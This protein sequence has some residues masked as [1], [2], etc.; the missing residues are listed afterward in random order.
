M[1]FFLVRLFSLLALVVA[2]LL[3]P[4]VS[5]F[6]EPQQCYATLDFSEDVGVSRCNG[7]TGEHRIVIICANYINGAQTGYT[8]AWVPEYNVSVASCNS[9]QYLYT[10]FFETRG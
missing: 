7:G 4:S 9:W 10:G 3:T 8:G 1:K 2:A 6:A 5:A